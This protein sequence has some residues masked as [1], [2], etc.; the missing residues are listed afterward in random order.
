MC[1]YEKFIIK[2][3]FFFF[4]FLGPDC[5]ERGYFVRGIVLAMNLCSRDIRSS[6]LEEGVF[7]FFF[8]FSTR[9]C[10]NLKKAR[11]MI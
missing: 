6:M 2:F 8:F 11:R 5:F 4:F 10:M 7:F 1:F 3:V 9:R